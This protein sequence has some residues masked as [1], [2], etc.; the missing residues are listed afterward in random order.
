M[1]TAL[2]TEPARPPAEAVATAGTDGLPA[3]R[4]VPD[5]TVKTL[6]TPKIASPMAPLLDDRQTTEHYVDE[7][8]RV[9]LDDT[10]AGVTGRG[11]RVEELPGLEP[12]GPRRKIF[13]DPSK[14]RVGDRHLRRAV[15]GP[16]RRHRR[17]RAQPDLPLQ[18]APGHRDPQRLPGLHRRPTGTTSSS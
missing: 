18:G 7:A 4:P 2:N 8:D 10:L 11:R 17:P 6:G 5:L 15:P 3:A 14:T 1:S 13:F 12:C 9:L 16:Q